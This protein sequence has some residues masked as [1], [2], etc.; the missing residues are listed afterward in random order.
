MINFQFVDDVF[1]N[2]FGIELFN[3]KIQFP[4]YISQSFSTRSDSIK[5]FKFLLCLIQLHL[6]CL[7]ER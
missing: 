5:M 2:V 1:Y 7:V 4:G 6:T 3:M